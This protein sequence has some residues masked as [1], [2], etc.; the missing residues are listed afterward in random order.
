VFDTIDIDILLEKVDNYGVRGIA[1]DWFR[2]YLKGRV[3]FVKINSSSSENVC[4]ILHG[5]PQGSI[6]GPLLF[7]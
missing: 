2:S 1:N 5:V 4:D 3:Q 7:T 6:L